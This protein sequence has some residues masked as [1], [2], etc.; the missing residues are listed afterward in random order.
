METRV[1]ITLGIAEVAGTTHQHALKVGNNGVVTRLWGCAL[2]PIFW[3]N[4]LRSVHGLQGFQPSGPELR[5]SWETYQELCCLSQSRTI[6]LHH[7][8]PLPKQS[9]LICVNLQEMWEEKKTKMCS[10]VPPRCC[11]GQQIEIIASTDS[12]CCSRVQH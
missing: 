1:L 4:H 12:L 10:H 9:Y 6:T 2:Q 3:T 11:N 7:G 8:G 5:G